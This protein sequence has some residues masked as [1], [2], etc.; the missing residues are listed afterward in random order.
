LLILAAPDEEFAARALRVQAG[1]SG[2][3]W[4]DGRCDPGDSAGVQQ[5]P[6]SMVL[7]GC[8]ASTCALDL[9]HAEV[10]ALSW[11]FLCTDRVVIQDLLPPDPAILSAEVIWVGNEH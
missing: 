6:E 5:H 3:L 10:P 2:F 11:V 9:L 8:E 4:G 1:E 7:G